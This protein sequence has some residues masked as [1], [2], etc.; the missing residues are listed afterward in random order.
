MGNFFECIIS[1]QFPF[2]TMPNLKQAPKTYNLN[3]SF[4]FGD[5]VCGLM[6][7]ARMNFAGTG[8]PKESL[9]SRRPPS[10]RLKL[11]RKLWC[12]RNLS[13]PGEWGESKLLSKPISLSVRGV[14]GGGCGDIG[15]PAGWMPSMQYGSLKP[16]ISKKIKPQWVN[17]N[18]KFVTNNPRPAT[19]EPRWI[20][21]ATFQANS[22]PT[23]FPHRLHQ[24]SIGWLFSNQDI[25]SSAPNNNSRSI[26]VT[27]N[28]EHFTKSSQSISAKVIS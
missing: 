10:L 16:A 14:S 21:E 6:E 15:A 27:I 12:F 25:L 26:T 7:V 23:W 22:F 4:H 5:N 18:V 1:K 24:L 8:P 19:C 11:N 28:Y 9:C 17:S 20:Q 3:F 2:E 13:A